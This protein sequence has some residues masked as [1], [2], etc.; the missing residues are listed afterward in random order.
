MAQ[1]TSD[2]LKEMIYGTTTVATSHLVCGKEVIL[3][4]LLRY[5]LPFYSLPE[6][7]QHH[8]L[9]PEVKYWKPFITFT[10]LPLYY[11]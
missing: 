3:C 10:N 4:E 2:I 6:G 7:F 1:K 9:P 5:D 11:D 8:N